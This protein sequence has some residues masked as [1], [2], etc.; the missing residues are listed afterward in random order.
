MLASILDAGCHARR[1]RATSF[2]TAQ[3]ARSVQQA[4]HR[5]KG[6]EGAVGT[7]HQ[8]QPHVMKGVRHPVGDH[9]TAAVGQLAIVKDA[10]IV[11]RGLVNPQ[12]PAEAGM[13]TIVDFHRIQVASSM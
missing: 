5:P 12:S 2:T 3:Q 13:P 7:L 11:P 1:D 8:D 6:G 9:A 10:A 4:S